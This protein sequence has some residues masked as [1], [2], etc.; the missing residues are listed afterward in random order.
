MT[1]LNV[2]GMELRIRGLEKSFGGNKVLHPFDLDFAPGEFVG[3]NG[4][5]R[6]R[7]VDAVEDPCRSP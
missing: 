2:K 7:Q 5:Q 3:L 6:S 1:A 4:T